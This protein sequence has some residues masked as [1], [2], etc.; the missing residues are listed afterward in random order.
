EIRQPVEPSVC[1]P[2]ST[3]VILSGP[4]SATIERGSAALK[5]LNACRHPEP[6]RSDVVEHLGAESRDGV[7]NPG[8]N[9]GKD[10]AG[11]ES[12]MFQ[13]AERL[14]QRLLADAF[15]L[16]HDA[17]EAHGPAMFGNHAHGPER[18]L[19]GYAGDHFACECIFGFGQCLAE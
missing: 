15:D 8:R 16:I 4:K 1:A 10:L 13:S 9:L 5:A 3:S 14:R 6:E 2:I 17:G 12:V 11:Y 19:V 18:P 7:F